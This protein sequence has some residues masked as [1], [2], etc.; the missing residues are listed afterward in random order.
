MKQ[1]EI[2]KFGFWRFF[3]I[4]RCKVVMNVFFNDCNFELNLCIRWWKYKFID[5]CDNS[6]FRIWR[7]SAQ[8]DQKPP[9][10]L[11]L[12]ERES[13]G[14]GKRT[15]NGVLIFQQMLRFLDTCSL[16]PVYMQSW[17]QPVLLSS[18]GALTQ[19]H[20]LI[21]FKLQADR[22]A[23]EKDKELTYALE[24][25]RKYENVS[26]ADYLITLFSNV[27]ITKKTP[28]K[29]HILTV[30]YPHFCGFFNIWLSWFT[31]IFKTLF[32]VL[33]R[34]WFGRSSAGNKGLQESNQS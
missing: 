8:K 29:S 12:P 10:R 31:L 2:L 11:G 3:F 23:R 34:I 22:D 5:I 20:V 21:F 18:S 19:N 26:S 4:Y 17:I 33:G 25:Q 27:S 14:A 15:Q 24:K 16:F 30:N 32:Y 6:W 1:F 28:S 9:E 13:H 7:Q